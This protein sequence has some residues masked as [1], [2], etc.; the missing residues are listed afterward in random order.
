MSFSNDYEPGVP[1]SNVEEEYWLQLL[2]D[3]GS[4]PSVPLSM[5]PSPQPYV[6]EH[7]IPYSDIG[8]DSPQLNKAN[9]S[10]CETEA[11]LDMNN[12]IISNTNTN[13][14][15]NKNIL[16]IPNSP[17]RSQMSL[18]HISK[19]HLANSTTQQ[20]VSTPTYPPPPPPPA[21]HRSQLDS[22]I[23]QPPA[24]ET[25]NE[26]ETDEEP[27]NDLPDMW[28][29]TDSYVSDKI[30][31][32]FC[33]DNKDDYEDP[34]A[35][36]S[37]SLDALALCRSSLVQLQPVLRNAVNYAAGT[38]KVAGEVIYASAAYKLATSKALSNTLNQP[39]PSIPV[40]VQDTPRYGP[41]L[42]SLHQT[43][44]FLARHLDSI[45]LSK[46][47]RTASG[48]IVTL[49]DIAIMHIARYVRL[50]V[51][52]SSFVGCVHESTL[53]M[54]D[55]LRAGVELYSHILQG[56]DP[57]KMH[58][59]LLKD[60]PDWQHLLLRCSMASLTWKQRQLLEE[61]RDGGTI[62]SI[63][64]QRLIQSQILEFDR[65]RV[66]KIAKEYFYLSPE[67]FR[68]QSDMIEIKK[69]YKQGKGEMIYITEDDDDEGEKGNSGVNTMALK[70]IL[71]DTT[72]I[73]Q[74]TTTMNNNTM[75]NAS[76]MYNTSS[77]T[78]SNPKHNPTTT[79]T[80]IEEE[81]GEDSLE[82]DFERTKALGALKT[83]IHS[84]LVEEAS[85][86]D[87]DAQYALAR[88]FTPPAFTESN[89]CTICER[90]FSITLFRHHCRFC[91]RS[92]CDDHSRGNYQLFLL[93]MQVFI[94]TIIS[95]IKTYL[96]TT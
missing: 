12:N 8:C 50:N 36:N 67:T 62:S 61:T 1:D 69:E 7:E 59:E 33:S 80:N 83:N 40:S 11:V 66:A 45:A 84:W 91:A 14:D 74:L 30:D 34:S 26:F 9:K 92:V 85:L 20:R 4:E 72:S 29:D 22:S 70:A 24:N 71:T 75:N 96:Y 52:L 18:S 77:N 55:R 2:S 44:L 41:S 32:I 76:N 10:I 25:E 21:N 19:P 89:G 82:T 57:E 47:V 16:P 28:G 31:F 88:F 68:I 65:Q 42:G 95:Y 87:E 53:F 93:Y 6:D 58:L 56:D 39:S 15:I 51:Y 63:D 64:F 5:R 43:I 48:S 3:L 73:D 78:S 27:E 35:Y 38:V 17:S 13:K 37:Q 86:G 94:Y 46:Y 60:K 79:T 90:N 81:I 54:V 49:R 23:Q